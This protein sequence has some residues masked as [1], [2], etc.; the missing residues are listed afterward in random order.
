MPLGMREPD[1][2]TLWPSS[3][4]GEYDSTTSDATSATKA[5]PKPSR[6]AAP[7]LGPFSMSALQELPAKPLALELVKETF[8]SFN[9]FLPLFDE[10]D[11]LDEFQIKY[12]SSMPRD[13][14]W[15]ACL[16]VVLSMAHRFCG[17][18]AIDPSYDNGRACGYIHNALT[19][20]SELT[21]CHDSL[22][23]VQA[24]VGMATIIQGTANY[25]PSSALIAA[26]MRLA[27]AMNLHQ[28]SSFGIPSLTTSQVEQRRRVFWI[29]YIVD[30][31]ISLRMGHPFSQD[32]DDMDVH[33]PT[34]MRDE[35]PRNED[36]LC[37]LELLNHRI[38]LAVIQGQVY[39]KLYSVQARRQ[40][41]SQNA[42]AAQELHTLLSYW[43]SNVEVDIPDELSMSSVYHISSELMHK[44]GLRLTYV[45]C[46]TMIDRHMPRTMKSSWSPELVSDE[47]F[48]RFDSTCV[49]ESRKAI[50]LLK[51]LPQG[52]FA[53]VW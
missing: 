33:L 23:A 30:K 43:K 21:I 38:S 50:C 24:L 11:F 9:R 25:G 10:V 22:P 40:S 41:E 29:A 36:P 18:R 39:K 3:G 12:S 26:A 15:W 34:K 27:Q 32:D 31:D 2:I 49:L 45:H 13:P 4:A 20:V 51:V 14:T 46:L 19:V 16:N 17:M 52:H 53:C 28:E 47:A 35:I 6:H 44:L 1:A 8:Q 48:V 7:D 5:P 37:S 42:R